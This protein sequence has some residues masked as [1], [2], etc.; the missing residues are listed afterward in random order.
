MAVASTTARL[1]LVTGTT[2][3][4]GA[5]L[6]KQLLQRGWEVAGVARRKPT[7]ENPR[8]HHL[9]VDLGDV[10][11]AVKSIESKLGPLLGERAWQRVGLVNNAA[12]ASLLGPVQRLDAHELVRLYAINVAIPT[13]LM[14][15]V[16]RNSHRGAM[17]RIVNL[18]SGAA[19]R[20]FPG[21]AAYCGGKAALRMAGMAFAAELES[22]LRS[23][24]TP[25]VAILSYEP[26]V[27]DTE[28]QLATRSKSQEEFPWV[29]TFRG[30][31]AQGALV[32][33][34][35]PAAEI[36]EFLEADGRAHFI[37]RRRGG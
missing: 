14:G 32:A 22:P 28:M 16:V 36:V 23:T 26:G 34:E 11:M 25:D 2:S 6:A 13:W 5:A 1:A 27:V 3:G 31:A 19:V 7:L 17:I 21:L 10:P 20:A 15:F 9:A 29:E 8:Y 18:S 12:S 37:E 33:P 30:F 35:I 24:A 4:I